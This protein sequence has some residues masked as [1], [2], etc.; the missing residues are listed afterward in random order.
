MYQ[1]NMV[2]DFCLTKMIPLSEK[3]KRTGLAEIVAELATEVVAATFRP[4]AGSRD[5]NHNCTT[6][7]TQ[8]YNMWKKRHITTL[9][10]TNINKIKRI[11]AAIPPPII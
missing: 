2:F 8:L 9:I 11:R 3:E 7:L 1:D 6:K 10:S 5:S 4:T